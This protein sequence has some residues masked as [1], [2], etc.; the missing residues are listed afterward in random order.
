MPGATWKP[1]SAGRPATNYASYRAAWPTN[2]DAHLQG[3]AAAPHQLLVR[4]LSLVVRWSTAVSR[5]RLVARP[6]PDAHCGAGHRRNT[7]RPGAGVPRR[8]GP[9]GGK[10]RAFIIGMTGL[11][12]A[13]RGWRNHPPTAA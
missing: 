9:L 1:A 11:A 8:G 13:E 10:R 6:G 3:I 12:P 5:S 2:K 7:D 4:A